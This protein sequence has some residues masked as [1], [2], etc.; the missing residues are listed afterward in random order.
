MQASRYGDL[1]EV[2]TSLSSGMSVSSQDTQGRTGT[3]LQFLIR[4]LSEAKNC[5]RT[6]RQVNLHL[7]TVFFFLIAGVLDAPRAETDFCGTRFWRI[8]KVSTPL[9]YRLW[10]LMLGCLVVK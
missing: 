3:H 2:Q 4:D 5:L 7:D 1:E 8:V 10:S 6:S 9:V